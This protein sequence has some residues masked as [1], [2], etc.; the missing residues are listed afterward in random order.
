MDETSL[1]PG[2]LGLV[3]HGGNDKKQMNRQFQKSAGEELDR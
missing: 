1:A 3:S 2:Q